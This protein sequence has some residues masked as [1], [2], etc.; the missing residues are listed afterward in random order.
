MNNTLNAYDEKL[1]YYDGEAVKNQ[2]AYYRSLRTLAWICSMLA[3]SFLLYDELDIRWCLIAFGLFLIAGTIVLERAKSKKYQDNY[4]RYRLLAEAVRVQSFLSGAGIEFDIT[5]SFLWMQKDELSFV[6]DELGDLYKTIDNRD[7][8]MNEIKENWLLDQLNY[9]KNAC[10]KMKRRVKVDARSSSILFA[11]AI[12]IFVVALVLEYLFPKVL[13]VQVFGLNLS[14][15]IKTLFGELSVISLFV[16]SYYGK[17]SLERTEGDHRKM[18]SLYEFALKKLEDLH[19][20]DELK[21]LLISIAR[22]EILENA[23][24]YIYSKET[25]LGIEL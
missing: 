7:V 11:C 18:I 9:H 25:S 23:N 14:I 16:S 2:K 20:A 12:F 8:S 17:L 19:S 24:W 13:S 21:D 4:L 5:S 6:K 22:E 3:L 1:N 10:D 15:I